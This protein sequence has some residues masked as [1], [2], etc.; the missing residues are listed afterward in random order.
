VHFRRCRGRACAKTAKLRATEAGRG[1]ETLVLTVNESF[2]KYLCCLT[3]IVV[4]LNAFAFLHDCLTC[5]GRSA[6]PLAM[7]RIGDP[8]SQEAAPAWDGAGTQ[9][10]RPSVPRHKVLSGEDWSATRRRF[11]GDWAY[12]INVRRPSPISRHRVTARVVSA[13]FACRPRITP[14]R[15][16]FGPSGAAG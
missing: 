11:H 5:L 3:P 10:R 14:H 9:T 7:S 1:G 4:P 6:P 15:L 16:Q 8:S 12:T 13:I 2:S